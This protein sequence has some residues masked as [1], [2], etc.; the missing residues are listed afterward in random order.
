MSTEGGLVPDAD[1][2][3]ESLT[4][5][6]LTALALSADPRPAFDPATPPWHAGY[7]DALELLPQWYMPAP[8]GRRAGTGTR[9]AVAVIVA[10]FVLINALGLCV[11][12]GIVTLA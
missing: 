12:Y 6:E 11:T 7:R 8:H 1:D 4:D 2:V 10:S 9:V 5:E 3:S